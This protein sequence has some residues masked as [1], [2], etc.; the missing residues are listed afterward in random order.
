[1]VFG[2]I[3]GYLL[4]SP[5]WE[6]ISDSVQRSGGGGLGRGRLE[7]VGVQKPAAGDQLYPIPHF[8][9]G[10]SSEWN[11]ILI[12]QLKAQVQEQI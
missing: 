5:G 1:M 3:S 4:L 10:W 8:A 12:L 2:G 7:Q 6:G 11:S 9:W